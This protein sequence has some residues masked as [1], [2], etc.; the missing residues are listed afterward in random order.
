MLDR[1][2]QPNLFDPGRTGQPAPEATP[3]AQAPTDHFNTPPAAKPR[4]R[5]SAPSLA[6][7][8]TA[9]RAVIA[10]ALAGRLYRPRRF[11]LLAPVAILLLLLVANPAG[12]G[13]STTTRV[14]T[15]PAGGRQAP[16]RVVTR[17][18]TRTVTV[19]EPPPATTPPPPHTTRAPT[20]AP[21]HA[22]K[23]RPALAPQLT[24]SDTRQQT[25]TA[26]PSP[27][28]ATVA[29]T[30]PA[31]TFTDSP[32]DPSREESGEEFGFER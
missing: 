29:P 3:A 32:P 14:V 27:A 28:S 26:I 15:Q 18:V 4:G 10:A 24:A 2:P 8:L 22:T 1:S 31:M 5:V 16:P 19:R 9:A 7:Y 21:A 30:G 25:V 17:L 23:V 20:A 11:G 13:R 6:R 12:C